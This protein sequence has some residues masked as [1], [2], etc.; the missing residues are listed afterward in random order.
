[1]GIM[2]SCMALPAS[3]LSADLSDFLA[4]LSHRLGRMVPCPRRLVAL[5]MCIR[6]GDFR[7]LRA[8]QQLKLGTSFRKSR[9]L[10]CPSPSFSPPSRDCPAT[11]AVDPPCQFAVAPFRPH[12]PSPHTSPAHPVASYCSRSFC[13]VSP[14]SSVASPPSCS[15]ASPHLTL[16]HRDTRPPRT[17]SGPSAKRD[18]NIRQWRKRRTGALPGA[19]WRGCLAPEGGEAGECEGVR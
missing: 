4:D 3:D 13:V 11:A 14:S 6:A 15:V 2:M 8:A 5:R 7:R 10:A 1:M 19:S 16:T 18:G 17:C 9:Y 12:A